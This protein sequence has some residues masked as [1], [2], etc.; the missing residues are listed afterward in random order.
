MQILPLLLETEGMT[1]CEVENVKDDVSKPSGYTGM[2][3][4]SMF[5]GPGS[6]DVTRVV[7]H[8]A[9]NFDG[10]WADLA[11]HGD[12][13]DV[14]LDVPW[15]FAGKG[16]VVQDIPL[17]IGLIPLLWSSNAVSDLAHN[18]CLRPLQRPLQAQTQENSP[19]ELPPTFPM[20][21]LPLPFSAT[22]TTPRCRK[23]MARCFQCCG[24]GCGRGWTI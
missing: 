3:S 9:G 22:R 14:L 8:D 18:S 12:V 7:V 10:Q 21:P 1:P 11:Q 15:S 6:H 23:S 4:I 24:Q 17:V 20:P 5:S 13:Q 16:D 19:G 2:F